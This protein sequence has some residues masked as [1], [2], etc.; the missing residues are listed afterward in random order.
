[1]RELQWFPNGLYLFYGLSRLDDL[2][3]TEAWKVRVSY[4]DRQRIPLAGPALQVRLAPTG[5]A[6]A[7]VTGDAINDGKGR[8]VIA[9]IEGGG[10]FTLTDAPGRYSGLAWSPQGD[11][12]SYAEVTDE[13]HAEIWIADGD[14]SGRLAAHSYALEFSD[15]SI[16]LS[17]AFRG[18]VWMATFERR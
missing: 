6:L 4:P 12:L 18:P 16:V 7:Y 2:V 8:V 11:K 3:I 10:R 15:P 13:A 9:G 1:M 5:E 17:G 14:D